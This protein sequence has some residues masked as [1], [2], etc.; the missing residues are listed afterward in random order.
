MSK[1]RMEKTILKAKLDCFVYFLLFN[2]TAMKIFKLTIS[3][4]YSLFLVHTEFD[5]MDV[6]KL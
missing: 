6:K 2:S 4:D 5:S 1:V 3:V